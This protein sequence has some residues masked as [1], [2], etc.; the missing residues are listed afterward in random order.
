MAESQTQREKQKVCTFFK[1]AGRV[2]GGVRK[3]QAEASDSGL[4]FLC[5]NGKLHAVAASRCYLKFHLGTEY[6]GGEIFMKFYFAFCTF[7]FDSLNDV[8]YVHMNAK[9]TN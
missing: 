1:K 3:R 8:T 4:W 6:S 9:C 7:Q 2:R 5:E